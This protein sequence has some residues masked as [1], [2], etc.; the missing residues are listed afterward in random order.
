MTYSIALRVFAILLALICIV[1]MTFVAHYT[2]APQPQPPG[3]NFAFDPARA[4]R[5]PDTTVR[6]G[7]LVLLGSFVVLAGVCLLIAGA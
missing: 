7:T 5:W 1:L 6:L 3:P 2:H 4:P